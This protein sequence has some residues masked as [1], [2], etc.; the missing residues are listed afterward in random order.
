M[1]YSNDS[2]QSSVYIC[3]EIF[4]ENSE[5]TK[6]GK[7]IFSFVPFFILLNCLWITINCIHP[8]VCSEIEEQA[9]RLGIDPA[10]ELHLLYI[11]KKCLLEPLPSDWLPWY[12][13]QYCLLT[14]TYNVYTQLYSLL[15][16]SGN[17]LFRICVFCSYIIKENKY[18]YY[19]VQS[20]TSQWEHPLDEHYRH[21]VEKIRS[22]DSS[23]G[24]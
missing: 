9:L 2:A 11:A 23:T 4:D 1:T 21:I 20:K 14:L 7:S 17:V 8:N 10:N 16:S 24:E 15:T 5:P 3:K 13:L 6:I 22:E 19:N 18:F 12:I